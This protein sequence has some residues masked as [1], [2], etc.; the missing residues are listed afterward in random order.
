MP[1]PQPPD[2]QPSLLPGVAPANSR[3]PRKRFA[4]A[5]TPDEK[6]FAA[7]LRKTWNE[8]FKDHGTRANSVRRNDFAAIQLYRWLHSPANEAS[9]DGTPPMTEAD[10]VRAIKAYASDDYNA[11][12][13]HGVWK[14]FGDWLAGC[15]DAVDKQL[16]KIGAKRGAVP[17][18]PES[19]KRRAFAQKLLDAEPYKL[20]DLAIR[21]ARSRKSLDVFASDALADYNERPNMDLCGDRRR[22][23]T[24]LLDLMDAFRHAPSPSVTVDI[25]ERARKGFVALFGREPCIADLLESNTCA[26]LSLALFARESAHQNPDRKGVGTSSSAQSAEDNA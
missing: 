14:C 21:A 25:P 15:P 12:K 9:D 11:K 6:Q 3:C 4:A 18:D 13:L 2:N 16:G 20:G 7:L 26:A 5:W 24:A 8:A 19:A 10:V 1:K 22:Y 17:D 23:Y